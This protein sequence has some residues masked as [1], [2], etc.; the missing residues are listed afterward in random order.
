MFAF[1]VLS[2]SLASCRVCASV[3]SQA[4]TL[5]CECQQLFEGC[6]E[7]F[8]IDGDCMLSRLPGVSRDSF[9]GC[10]SCECASQTHTT[11]FVG[12]SAARNPMGG[13]APGARSVPVGSASIGRAVGRACWR[14]NQALGLPRP[15]PR[16]CASEKF[17]PLE[18]IVPLL[19]YR[20]GGPSC[21]AAV[22]LSKMPGNIVPGCPG[23]SSLGHFV[24]QTAA[25]FSDA[26]ARRGL[27]VSLFSVSHR[28]TSL[29][30]I[31]ASTHHGYCCHNLCYCRRATAHE[32]SWTLTR[33]SEWMCSPCQELAVR[34]PEVG[35]IH[36]YLFVLEESTTVM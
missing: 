24:I 7:I 17:G 12:S 13:E 22:R 20:N 31:P 11:G 33:L 1:C 16:V 23:A 6:L 14:V 26:A 4:S 36:G 32:L 9:S 25:P 3:A 18:L 2:V 30:E 19:P 10:W 21:R 8:H 15:P 34:L 5:L 28:V 29:R 35:C 27:S